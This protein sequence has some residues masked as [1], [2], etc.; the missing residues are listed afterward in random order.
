VVD[1]W[2][3]TGDLGAV[4]EDGWLRLVGRAKD[5]IIRGGHNIDP[6]PVEQVLLGHPEVADAGVVGRPDPRSGEVPMAFVVLRGADVDLDSVRAWAADRVPEPAAAPVHV[7]ALPALPVTAVGKPD[8]VALR[9]LATR[10]RVGRALDEAGVEAGPPESWCWAV[11]GVVVVRLAVR[12]EAEAA[13]AREV[14]AQFGLDWRVEVPQAA[15]TA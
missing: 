12:D 1:G 2:L 6:A 8:K 7:V 5:V 15:P 14:L 9:V 3:D 11:D 10:L 4:G 13:R